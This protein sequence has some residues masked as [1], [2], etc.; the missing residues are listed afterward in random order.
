MRFVSTTSRTLAIL[1]PLNPDGVYF[2]LDFRIAHGGLLRA[3]SIRF[4]Q[5]GVEALG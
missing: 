1:P 3:F 4:R 2:R 5:R